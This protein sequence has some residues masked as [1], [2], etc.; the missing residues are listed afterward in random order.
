MNLRARLALGLAVLS[1]AAATTAAGVAYASTAGR[2][3]AEVDR[4]LEQA[5]A[6]LQAI[7]AGRGP[8][9]RSGG[10]PFARPGGP[11]GPLGAGRGPVGVLGLV[12]V[13]YLGPS[14]NVA[15]TE[16][17][18]ALPVEARDRALAA[19]GGSPWLRT[20]AVDGLSYRVLTQPLQSGGAV[21]LARDLSGNQA[22]LGSLRWR[23]ALLDA[24]VVALAAL[25]GWAFARR[26]ASPLQ[27]LASAAE[28]VASTGR[29]DVVVA[30]RGGDETGRL[31]EAFSTMLSALAR[32]RSQQQH[33]AEDAAHELRT[34][35][36][37][38][39]TNVDIL[40]R[41]EALPADARARV[42]G[43]LDTE[44]KEL[45][46]LVDELVELSTERYDE[47]PDG[48][49]ALDEVVQS[50]VERARQRSGRTIELA[51]QP[52]LVTGKKRAITRAVSNL[53]DNAIKFTEAPGLIE[54]SVGSGR[55]EVRDHGPGIAPPDLPRVFDR[56]YRSAQ[57]R[58]QAGSGLGLAIVAHVA[59]SHGGRAFAANHPGGGAVVGF[60]LPV[61]QTLRRSE[62]GDGAPGTVQ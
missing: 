52:C 34:P 57:A 55:V 41:H 25:A 61:S 49:V 29:L 22:V 5:G 53:V 7:P 14:G 18:V 47:E 46:G 62:D 40:R 56:F 51:V 1:A 39:R 43:A 3:G 31:A 60:E 48:P 6:R 15:S 35:L 19:S 37:S 10:G 58:G 36:T 8:F 17:E 32:S 4:S 54:V 9:A 26:V 44:L 11:Y 30:P 16:G 12:V 13:Q 23:F 42:L 50:V 21:Q 33:L 28:H 59:E 45:T 27:R 24:I 2:L 38:L 20:E